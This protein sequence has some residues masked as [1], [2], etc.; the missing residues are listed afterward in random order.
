M[1]TIAI[2]IDEETLRLID[3]LHRS[4]RRFRSRSA[5]VRAAIRAYASQERE[6]LSRDRE[7]RVIRENKRP[8]DRQ[9]K[10]MVQEQASL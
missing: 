5:L 6:R 2:T 8:L 10:A 1:R 7:L 3:Q 9:L 4:S